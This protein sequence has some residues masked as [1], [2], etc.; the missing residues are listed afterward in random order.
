MIILHYKDGTSE[1]VTA[2]FRGRVNHEDYH[3]VME[4]LAGLEVLRKIEVIET[5]YG[6]DSFDSS[7]KYC[8]S[9][10]GRRHLGYYCPV[11]LDKKDV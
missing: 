6:W 2:L 11:H 1:D 10:R 5:P 8:N 7:C 9:I 3:K 4:F